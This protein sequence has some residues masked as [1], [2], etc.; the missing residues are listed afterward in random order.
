M[1]S[2]VGMFLPLF[3]V[4]Y[5]ETSNGLMLAAVELMMLNSLL[6]VPGVEHAMRNIG[7]NLCLL[8]LRAYGAARES[9]NER[10]RNSLKLSTCSH[11]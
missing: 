2:F 11:K 3:C 6:I 1:R 8:V 5:L 10:T 7:V 9:H 4:V